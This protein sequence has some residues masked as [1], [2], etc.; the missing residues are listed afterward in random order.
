MRTAIPQRIVVV[1]IYHLVM[2]GK[3]LSKKFTPHVQ[4]VTV[5]ADVIVTQITTVVCGNVATVHIAVVFHMQS[6]NL[7]MVMMNMV[8]FS[9][10]DFRAEHQTKLEVLN[11]PY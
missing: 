9:E 6:F 7:Q 11:P 2:I 1:C 10:T 4:M 5:G 8:I 3:E